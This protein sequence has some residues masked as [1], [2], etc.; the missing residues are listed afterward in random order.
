MA[1]SNPDLVV[2]LIKQIRFG[3]TNEKGESLWRQ[4]VGEIVKT[5]EV[6]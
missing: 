3:N 5:K 6:K 4:V 2:G 1:G